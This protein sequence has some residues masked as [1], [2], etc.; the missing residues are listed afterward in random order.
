VLLDSTTQL[1]DGSRVRLRLPHAADRSGL[2]ALHQRVGVLAD[3]L[4]L[5]RVLRFDPRRRAVVCATAWVGGTE[6][7]VGYGAID[8]DDI[9]PHLLIA[10]TALAPGLHVLLE[11]ALIRHV[12]AR[13]A[14]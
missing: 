7:I 11:T 14:A 8:F 5:A 4:D 2:H 6:T 10:D 9:A 13:H 3:D 12:A 1:P